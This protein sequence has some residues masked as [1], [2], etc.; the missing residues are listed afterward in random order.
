MPLLSNEQ[1]LFNQRLLS[2]HCVTEERAKELWRLVQPPPP[3]DSDKHHRH[4]IPTLE[5]TLGHINCHMHRV[6]LEIRG[7]SVN[8]KR[9]YAWVNTSPDAVAIKHAAKQSSTGEA[10]YV[11]A[12][13]RELVSASS[14]ASSTSDESSSSSRGGRGVGG[15]TR[16]ELLNVRDNHLSL[17]AAELALHRL[18]DEKWLEWSDS[19]K[20]KARRTNN[21]RL[22]LAPRTFL[23]LGYLL[24]D[25]Y[26][27][28]DPSDLPQVIL[29]HAADHGVD[30]ELDNDDE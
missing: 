15:S 11:R 5:D 28:M 22:V 24:V 30:D 12:V 16:A 8:G 14:S 19:T 29:H 18:L 23:E 6:G 21:S 2:E 3:P 4:S 17:P 13:L 7:L 10:A 20:N 26:F 9:F 25:D 27:G 1:I